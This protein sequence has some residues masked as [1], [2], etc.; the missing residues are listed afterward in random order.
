MRC[1]HIL[2][3]Y[4][5][6]KFFGYSKDSVPKTPISDA[7]GG[8]VVSGNSTIFSSLKIALPLP[9]LFIF[10]PDFPETLD[11]NHKTGFGMLGEGGGVL[12][13]LPPKCCLKWPDATHR[14][15]KG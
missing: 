4:C 9:P 3:C 2:P 8:G 13:P 12:N 5:S 7:I 10:S 15:R 1:T 14:I 11:A 6:F